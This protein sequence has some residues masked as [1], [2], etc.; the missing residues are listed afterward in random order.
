MNVGLQLKS[1]KA[2][3]LCAVCQFVKL[4][5]DPHRRRHCLHLVNDDH[6]R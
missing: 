3:N 1:K 2:P 5:L 6:D 4:L